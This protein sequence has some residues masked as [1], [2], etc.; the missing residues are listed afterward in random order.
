V[1]L[2]TRSTARSIPGSSSTT[3]MRD[4]F[5]MPG[6]FAALTQTEWRR[7]HGFP[8][9]ARLEADASSCFQRIERQIVSPR[10]LPSALS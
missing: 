5:I 6:T 10:P 9:R 2:S 3:R 7:R 4:C 1:P 8:C